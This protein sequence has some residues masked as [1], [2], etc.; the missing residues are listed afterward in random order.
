MISLLG[1]LL[2]LKG[3]EESRYTLLGSQGPY[4]VRLYQR[5]TL[6]KVSVPGSFSF[7]D[8]FMEGK[9]LLQEYLQGSNLRLEKVPHGQVFFQSSRQNEWEVGV[10]LNFLRVTSEIP[11]PVNRLIRLEEF[12]PAKM[13]VLRCNNI[14]T[15]EVYYQREEELRRW[16]NLKCYQER[17][18]AK[19]IHLNSGLP[20]PFLKDKEISIHV[21]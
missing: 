17:G 8:A 13:A 15:S 6:A 11:R 14:S 4:E 10:M 1:S 12:P 18:E 19:L 21:T 16:I 5:S 20:L 2:N 7:Q 3:L 9:N